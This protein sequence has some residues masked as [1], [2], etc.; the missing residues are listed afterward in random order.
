[1]T[2][3]QLQQAAKLVHCIRNAESWWSDLTS[4]RAA[5]LMPGVSKKEMSELGI[6]PSASA[7]RLVCS[8]STLGLSAGVEALGLAV[9]R[10]VSSILASSGAA[11]AFLIVSRACCTV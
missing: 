3:A 1:M 9:A 8:W 11:Q 6:C 10:T 2:P 5:S 4:D 7:D